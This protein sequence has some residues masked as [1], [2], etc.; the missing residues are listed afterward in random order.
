MQAATPATI[1]FNEGICMSE[2]EI[3]EVK[4]VWL[5]IGNTDNTEGRGSSLI[6]AVSEL[7]ET[8]VRLGYK[9][10]VMGSNAHVEK[11][12]AVKINWN[13]FTRRE[14]TKPTKE[15]EQEN[16]RNYN[17]SVAKEKALGLGMTEE[18]IAFLK[19]TK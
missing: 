4:E 14:I 8:A 10:G 12:I 5:T 11:S 17:A 16:M 13:W 19:G 15:D 3:Q 18:E 1:N 7:K 2:V 6:L 9:K